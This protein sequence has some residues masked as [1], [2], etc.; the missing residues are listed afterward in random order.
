MH[1]MLIHVVIILATCFSFT[2]PSLVVGALLHRD[3]GIVFASA[4]AGISFVFVIVGAVL[5]GCS[6]VI[7]GVFLA[8]VV[9]RVMIG[10]R[11]R[12]LKRR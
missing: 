9:I 8:L 1:A 6:G 5:G 12:V 2:F 10:V 3:N 4:G 11:R 7:A